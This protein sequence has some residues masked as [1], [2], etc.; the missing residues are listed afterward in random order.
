MQAAAAGAGSRG[1][2]L[3]VVLGVTAVGVS[4]AAGRA[5]AAQFCNAAQAFSTTLDTLAFSA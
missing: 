1:L 3:E 5:A 2:K 4:L